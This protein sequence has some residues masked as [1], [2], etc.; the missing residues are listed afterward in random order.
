QPT[1]PKKPKLPKIVGDSEDWCKVL[2]LI[3]EELL[4]TPWDSLG[5]RTM[6]EWVCMTPKRYA[7]YVVPV[8]EQMLEIAM[9]DNAERRTAL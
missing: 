5:G 7:E 3:A 9:E 1:Q 2:R 6:R 4:D 8:A